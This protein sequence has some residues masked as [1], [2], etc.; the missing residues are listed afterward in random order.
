MAPDETLELRAPLRHR[1][2]LT[3]PAEVCAVLNVHP[4]DQLA[5]DVEPDGRVVV[6]GLTTV[7]ATQRWQW[8]PE[9]QV[10][11]VVEQVPVGRSPEFEITEDLDSWFAAR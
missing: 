9:W 1:R 10:S 2:Q 8:T 4:G 7:P 3:V 11:D 6:R 5:F